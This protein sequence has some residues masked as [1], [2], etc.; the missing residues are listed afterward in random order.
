MNTSPQF[1]SDDN[2][3]VLRRMYEGGDDLTQSRIIDYCFVFLDR[4]R[5]LAFTQAIDDQDFQVC[6]SYYKA[7]KLWQAIVKNNMVPDHAA[8]SA[9]EAALTIKAKTV[10]GTADGWGCMQIKRKQ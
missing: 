8:I 10:D 5:A 2:G 6:I 4:Q 3:D 7:K 1:P 9:M